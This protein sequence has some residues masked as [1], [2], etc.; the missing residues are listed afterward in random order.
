[1][2]DRL[3]DAEWVIKLA[4]KRQIKVD[5]Q[6][7][8]EMTVS[9]LRGDQGFQRKE[10][11][12]L[13][14]WLKTRAALRRHQP[15]LHAAASA[16]PSRCG[17]TLKTPICCTLQGEDLFLDGLGEP[18][19]QQ[20]MELI[21]A[22]ERSTS[23]R[24]CRSAGTTC[25]YMPGYLGIP[26]E[27]MR[28]VPLGIN[29]EGYAPRPPRPRDGPFTIGYF[30]RI[31]PEKGLHVLADA[32][33]RLRTRPG[34]GASRLVAA[35]YLAPEHQA[36]LDGITSDL[37][38]WGLDGPVRVSRR[39]RSRAEDRVPA[40]PRRA[41]RCRRPTTSRRACSCSRR[42]RAA[43]R[44]CSRGAARFPRSS[45]RTG[46]GLIVEADN[47][48][49]LADGFLALWQRS[50]ARGGARRGRRRRRARALQRRRDG[51]GRRSAST[52][53]LAARR[54]SERH[55]AQ[56]LTTSPSRTRR[57]AATLPILSDVSLS[58]ERGDAVAIMGPSGSGKSTLLYIL[59][60][61]DA[62]TT[63][64]VTLDGQD[65][66]ALGEREQAAFR[67]G[68]IGF[69][70]Q[71]HSL[72]PQC[73]V[74]ENV[75]APTLVAPPAERGAGATIR[76]AARE[77]LAQ[78]GLGDR[79]DHRPGELSG[80]EKQRAALARA[81]IR[82][83]LLLLCDEP[84]GNLD[85][86]VR[87][88]RRLAAARSPRAPQHDPRRRHPQRRAGRAVSGALRDERTARCYV[89]RLSLNSGLLRIRTSPNA[90][91]RH[92]RDSAEAHHREAPPTTGARTSP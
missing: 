75:L 53:E 80:G 13:L 18:W 10:I 88:H 82:D 64:T 45:R 49:A 32:Y 21:R 55:R 14:D 17:A 62:P 39:G 77:L 27:K 85:R 38:A 92:D 40:Q 70:F 83:P 59:G 16:S 58:L 8:G 71:D 73:S 65:P 11:A 89:D 57:R 26:R 52:S 86:A 56:R 7:L 9:M 68:R 50:G 84:T 66:F 69:V 37:S 5:P 24:S 25:D 29:L 43:C 4:S 79:L 42:W 78:V 81:L 72:L 2:L 23:T 22:R 33:R 19:K 36:Y 67:N 6:S 15:A 44:S 34:I 87:R 91:L 63:G 20:S 54:S 90:E 3:W 30:A 1:M 31:A 60:A 41:C 47:P 28:L 51:R 61:L 74:L 48:E 76:R 46:G 35:G 12:K